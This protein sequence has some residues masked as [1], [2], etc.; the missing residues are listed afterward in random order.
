MST[1]SYW[2]IDLND[3]LKFVLFFSINKK[4]MKFHV[5]VMFFLNSFQIMDIDKEKDKERERTDDP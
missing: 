3:Q 1:N 4:E 2:I 5:S